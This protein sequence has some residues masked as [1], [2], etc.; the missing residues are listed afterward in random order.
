VS[1]FS[2]E[3]GGNNRKKT[4]GIKIF[5]FGADQSA[6]IILLF[7]DSVNFFSTL[8]GAVSFFLSRGD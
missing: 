3:G 1:F 2:K 8:E 5:T 6:I 7:F 4:E